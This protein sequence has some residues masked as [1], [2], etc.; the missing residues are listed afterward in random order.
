MSHLQAHVTMNYKSLNSN[1]SNFC[2]YQIKS[3]ARSKRKQ[4][5]KR[6]QMNKHKKLSIAC[7]IP[8]HRSAFLCR[9]QIMFLN[10]ITMS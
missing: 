6:H 4:N 1:R 7:H 2:G 5:V 3:F 10:Q 9:H 8:K